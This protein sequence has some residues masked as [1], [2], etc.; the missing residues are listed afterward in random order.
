MSISLHSN[1]KILC[2]RFYHQFNQNLPSPHPFQLLDHL[3]FPPNFRF[4]A[5]VDH[6]R[7]SIV[8]CNKDGDSAFS[9]GGDAF[10]CVMKF[11]GSSVALAERMREVANLIQCFPEENP[12][13]VLSAMGKTTNNLICAG[14]KAVS[15]GFTNV[16]EI[17]ELSLIKDVH[18]RTVNELG[19][20]V[21]VISEQLEELELL[22][23]GIARLKELT[24]RT[25]DKLV[26]FGECMSTRVFAAYL[27]SIGV[28][29]QQYDAF[30]IGFV[31][32]DD[33]TNADILD[34]TYP[35]VAA[36]LH[37]DWISNKAIPVVTGFLG[38]GCKSGEITALG[39]G[40]SDL[41]ATVIGK[42]LGLREIQV[43]K[44]VNGVLTCDP[45]IHPCAKPVPY[46]TF[47]EAAE[48]AY[49]GAQVLHPQ[50]MRPAM[51]SNIP[52]RVKN[53][54][55][56][57]APGTLISKD[58]D[59]TKALLTSIVLKQNVTM[60]DIVSTRMLGQFGFL[61][62]VFA[63]FE[64]LDISVDVVATSEELDHVVEELGK[65]AVVKLLPQRSIISLIGN[66]QYSSLI[67]EK[68]FSVFRRHN[69]N[70]QM[71]SQGASKVNMSLIVNDSEAEECVKAL[72]YSFFE[73]GQVALTNAK[74]DS[75]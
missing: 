8:Y 41:T 46:L 32:T 19:I 23:N 71:I 48:L 60:L 64:D 17:E 33:F 13:I 58:R 24:L 26:S 61:A 27:N 15:C 31:T 55:N 35:A 69:V 38:K 10:T 34:A 49:F 11:G 4:S 47:E 16:S 14:E 50:A 68:A 65:I 39:R 66:I 52:V 30:D 45:S 62:K 57:K 72:H 25:R 43:W 22:L 67:L 1:A 53:S 51:E 70:V 59:M 75:Y 20:D 36:K 21:S 42:A 18:L 54:Y 3:H 29:A 56:P 9:D 28:K 5:V 2:T 44:D 7:S 6:K 63:I 40:G 37:D 73:S 12:I 74:A